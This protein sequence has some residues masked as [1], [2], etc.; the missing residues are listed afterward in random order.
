[1]RS[2]TVV[3][4]TLTMCA[5]IAWLGAVCVEAQ[6]RLKPA[7]TNTKPAQNT[8]PDTTSPA[9][10]LV[11]KYCVTCHNERLKTANLLLDKA[12]ADQVANSSDTWERVVVQLR[13]RSM[14]PVN[15]PRPD[16]A[17]YDT[18]A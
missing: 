2:P 8:K 15:M 14:P 17:T 3:R 13:G 18:V 11:A 12:D 4:R 9:R 7:P 16:N 1:M 10:V 5:C 6:G